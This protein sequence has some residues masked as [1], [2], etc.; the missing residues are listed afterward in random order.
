[1]KQRVL[2][3]VEVSKK[4]LL[5]RSYDAA[6]S[7][8]RTITAENRFAGYS[9]I[10]AWLHGHGTTPG[11]VIVGAEGEGGYLSPL[12][13]ILVEEGFQFVPLPPEVV[14]MQR[15]A[16]GYRDKTDAIDLDVILEVLRR[17]L[18][19]RPTGSIAGTS[20]NRRRIYGLTQA[21]E[22][23]T[24]QRTQLLNRLQSLLAQYWPE[25]PLDESAPAIDGKAMLAV[26]AK[27]PTPG[28]LLE[29][30]PAAITRLIK[31]WSR[32][33]RGAETTKTLRRLAEEV[34]FESRRIEGL[35][36]EASTI[37]AELLLLHD[38]MLKVKKDL[39]SLLESD[40]VARELLDWRGL[41][42]PLVAGLMATIQPQETIK[43]EP[44]LA[45]LLGLAP[46]RW[47]S[48]NGDFHYATKAHRHRGKRVML[49]IAQARA[50]HHTESKIFVDRKMA[51]G[52]NYWHAH[53]CLA[54]H[55]VRDIWK[56]IHPA[57]NTVS[58][59]RAA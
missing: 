12:D 54:R 13:E 52:K 24:E 33:Q 56:I 40:P 1:M 59:E 49:L 58:L 35:G 15:K 53:K 36:V 19:Q 26:L 50:R 25:L 11:D 4:E 21:L 55:L 14:A 17:R 51:E 57:E 46:S 27:W 16:L 29:A 3:S 39:E 42:V 20:A 6:G 34:F 5:L 44:A 23:L 8:L 22:R 43:S 45:R 37:A 48:G 9:E 31:K 30:S 10:L 47:Q 28:K 18:G 7:P 38:V 41:G 32:G 2:V